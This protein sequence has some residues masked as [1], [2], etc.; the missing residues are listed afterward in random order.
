MMYCENC[1]RIIEEERCPVCGN[2][3]IRMPEPTD[4][5]F[6]TELDYVSSG[7]LED[8]LQQNGIPFLKRNVMGAGMAIRVGPM[9]DRS[10]FYIPCDRFGEAET[11][12]AELS[13][14]WEETTETI[15]E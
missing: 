5:C 8:L 7:I 1:M 13:S 3:R 15:T 2:K 14:N 11:L 6:L 9:L 10:R 12:A 4:P